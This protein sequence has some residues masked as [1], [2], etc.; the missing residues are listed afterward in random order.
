MITLKYIRLYFLE[1]FNSIFCIK[2]R[3]FKKQKIGL[4]HF[5]STN[6]FSLSPKKRFFN[7]IKVN[8]LNP[9]CLIILYNIR[10]ILYYIFLLHIS[11][12]FPF[13][14]MFT[15]RSK[16]QQTCRQNYQCHFTGNVRKYNFNSEKEQTRLLKNSPELRIMFWSTHLK[17]P[18]FF[19]YLTIL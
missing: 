18:A 13:T 15:F 14:E 10:I 7:L 12:T 5:A 16:I 19:H 6:L 2:M 4:L 1:K 8:N 11:T 17:S 9:S 3:N